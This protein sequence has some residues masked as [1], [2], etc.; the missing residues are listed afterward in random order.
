M[1]ENNEQR[2]NPSYSATA[3][4]KTE[5]EVVH[6]SRISEVASLSLLSPSPDD[7]SDTED[8]RY[9]TYSHYHMYGG[10]IANLCSATLGAGILAVPYAMAEA[11]LVI[12]GIFLVL[13]AWATV[14]SLKLLVQACHLLQ[15]YTY[16]GLVQQ[17]LGMSARRLC[18]VCM[19]IF[20]VGVA[21]S[22]VVAVGDILSSVLGGYRRISMGIVF[23]AAMLPLSMLKTMKRL[24]KAS[25]VGILSILILILTS[26]IHF[27]VDHHNYR[28]HS[29]G[30]ME[31]AGTTRH[32][33]GGIP[34]WPTAGVPSVLRA[35]PILL[36]AFS[37]QV[38]VCAIYHEFQDP[39]NFGRVIWSSVLCCAALY[40]IISV[41]TLV[42]VY[43][44]TTDTNES[45]RVPP[46]VLQLYCPTQFIW[47]LAFFS[48]AV[49]VVMA[50]P[51]NIF[52]AR[53]TLEGLVDEVQA[54][55]SGEST[56]ST[57]AA[58]SPL[59]QALLMDL[60]ED[61]VLSDPV[62]EES[63]LR[64]SSSRRREDAPQQDTHEELRHVILTV[65]LAGAAFGFALVV[66]NISV[67]FGLL[68][69]T[70]SSVLGFC[71]P[72]ALGLK[73]VGRSSM[74]SWMLLM[75]GMVVA[76]VTTA[77]TLYSTFTQMSSG[78]EVI[79]NP[80]ERPESTPN[81][82]TVLSLP[83]LYKMFSGIG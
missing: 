64:S 9:Y 50:F 75:G 52:P 23:L 28:H 60:E 21:V 46:N 56:T 73:I 24:Q 7:N 33:F 70:T 47:S 22:Y 31:E 14:V 1:P 79:P 77:V 83:V 53:V 40:T 82:T 59:Q 19:L 43:S 15:T 4:A 18:E 37:C 62:I 81:I 80:C 8:I 58:E 10:S 42:D 3:S 5:E 26:V 16:E 30:H 17:A 71:L 66:P 54:W 74:K 51:L 55:L 57:N 48:M 12:G 67:I 45:A 25:S 63:S 78:E 38:N 11:G 29:Q 2:N 68:G 72:G 32:H 27:G 61:G 6:H 13:S 34:L 41:V 39:P 69:G 44:F 36:F 49:A 65:I 35:C 76:I 20:C